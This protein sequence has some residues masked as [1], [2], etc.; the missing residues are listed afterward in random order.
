MIKKITDTT[1]TQPICDT[2]KKPI[3][4]YLERLESFY[5]ETQEQI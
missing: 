3:Y 1:E 2:C 4:G 5:Y